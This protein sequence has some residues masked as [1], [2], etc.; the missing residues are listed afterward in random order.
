[1]K[2]MKFLLIA[3]I[4]LVCTIPTVYAFYYSINK[5]SIISK[6]KFDYDLSQSYVRASIV[7]YW[8]DDNSCLDSNDITTRDISGISSWNVNNDIINPD[9]VL[10]S[11]GFY[12]YKNIIDSTEI[13]KDNIDES[14]LVIIDNT[15][16]F[17]ELTSDQIT[18]INLIPQYEVLYEF[19]SS[20]KVSNAWNVTYENG[21]PVKIN[22]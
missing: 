18:G 4:I 7:T 9:W 6:F 5:S 3:L 1:M 13:N 22:N 11:D 21:V 2:K 10:L 15:L 20:E 17:D 8:V 19:V 14:N 12:Y 16:P